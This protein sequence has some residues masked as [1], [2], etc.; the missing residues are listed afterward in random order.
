MDTSRY[1][2]LGGLA[3]LLFAVVWLVCAV[4]YLTQVGVPATMPTLAE[5]AQL[6]RS[7]AYGY[8]L[9][10]RFVAILFIIPF[11]LAG[12]DCLVGLAP[13]RARTGATFLFLYA[14]LW[15]VWHATMVASLGVAKVDPI[16]E[17]TLSIF[18]TLVGTLASAMS[19]AIA[20]FEAAWGAALVG[21]KGLEQVA[22]ASFLLG[23]GAAVI[24][25]IM[26]DSSPGQLE[27]I[28]SQVSTL[29]MIV[30]V[31]SLGLS[32]FRGASSPVKG[33]VP[34]TQRQMA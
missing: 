34:A 31:G 28:M 20:L 6:L 5:S 1:I 16:D 18:L 25:L 9:T 29:F 27:Q 21:R 3:G 30:G 23:A 19:W 22:G 4:A 24:I 13:G 2:R 26:P 33:D 15:F 14:T 7:P 17:P 12:R 10:A 32:M 8:I 11:A